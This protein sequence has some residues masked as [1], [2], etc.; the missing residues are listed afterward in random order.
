MNFDKVKDSGGKTNFETGSARDVQKG[1]GRP[2]LIPPC[3]LHREA[4][5]YEKDYRV[6]L[7]SGRTAFVTSTLN[8][9]LDETGKVIKLIGTIQDITERKLAE[10]SRLVSAQQWWS[11]FDAIQDVVFLIDIEGKIVQCNNATSEFTGKP[12]VEII[13]KPCFEVIHNS[14]AMIHVCPM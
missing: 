9:V 7:K 4:R 1:K 12:R 14:P 13:G 11:T 3:I 10:E 2:D 6:T 8:P 5:H